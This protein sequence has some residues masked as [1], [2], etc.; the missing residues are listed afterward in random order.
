MCVLSCICVSGNVC[1]VD[2]AENAIRK[3]I[4]PKAPE[5]DAD[6][7]EQDEKKEEGEA[8]AARA[9][10]PLL[11]VKVQ[12]KKEANEYAIDVALVDFTMHVLVEAILA[13]IDVTLE[14]VDA[15]MSMIESPGDAAAKQ[16][17]SLAGG[18]ARSALAMISEGAG[19]EESADDGG[20]E[21]I[22]RTAS[23][24]P[25]G[26]DPIG[27]CVRVDLK[28]PQLILVENARNYDSRALTMRGS[29]AV[30]YVKRYETPDTTYHPFL[31]QPHTPRFCYRWSMAH[32]GTH[33]IVHYG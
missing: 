2:S 23:Q 4:C 17:A 19:D 26:P 9:K 3:L 14:T 1:W 33:S 20:A 8:V 31:P 32:P 12:E 7:E 29:C 6:D 24:Q 11:T 21:Q 22:R 16:H 5:V 28:N 27:L 18:P 25:T 15:V 13:S 10:Q 30:A